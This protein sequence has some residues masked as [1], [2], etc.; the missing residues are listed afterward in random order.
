MEHDDHIEV[1]NQ[2]QITAKYKEWSKVL[3]L[4]SNMTT[5]EFCNT[6]KEEFDIIDDV[7][8]LRTNRV[9][10]VLDLPAIKGQL[11]NGDVVHIYISGN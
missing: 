8:V 10:N 6:L 1:L 4:A 9:A 2:V 7:K 11:H 3:R 5:R